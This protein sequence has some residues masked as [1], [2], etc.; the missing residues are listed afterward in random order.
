MGKFSEA[1]AK[2][3]STGEVFQM[4]SDGKG[5]EVAHIMLDIDHLRAEVLVD[6]DRSLQEGEIANAIESVNAKGLWQESGALGLENDGIPKIVY[7]F[8]HADNPREFGKM[9]GLFGYSRDFWQ[10]ILEFG[11]VD[12]LCV[13]FPEQRELLKEKVKADFADM[14][15]VDIDKCLDNLKGLRDG[16]DAESYPVDFRKK[17][18]TLI[19]ELVKEFLF[20]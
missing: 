3:P 5:A 4:M 17:I 2:I 15:D 11:M 9:I 18:E 19:F 6:L 16:R 1:I 13:R 8:Y 7:A 14:S 12:E 20:R 10:Q